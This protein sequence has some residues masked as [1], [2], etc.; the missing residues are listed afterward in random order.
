MD[1]SDQRTGCVND[2]K[3][4][5]PSLRPYRRGNT[6]CTKDQ[7]SAAG[8]FFQFLDK[9]RASFAQF[10]DN[11]LVVDDF[12]AHIDGSAVKIQCNFD[13]IYRTNDTSAKPTR[14]E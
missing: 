5:L 13:H 11:V 3:V 7:A 12:F 9:D 6:M 2:F 8:N 10:V 4:A 1:L 14:P